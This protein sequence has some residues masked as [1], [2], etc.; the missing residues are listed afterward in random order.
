MQLTNTVEMLID[1]EDAAALERSYAVT[2]KNATYAK[3]GD[4]YVHRIV[5]KAKDGEIVDHINFNT[6]DNRKENLRIVSAKQS[7]TYRR[8]YDKGTRV[9]Q[10]KGVKPNTGGFWM[11]RATNDGKETF[12]G[13]Y[14][15]ESEAARAYD[16]FAVAHHGDHA[17]LN[18]PDF[19]YTDYVPKRRKDEKFSVKQLDSEQNEIATYKSLFAASKA[20]GVPHAVIAKVC[21]G[22]KPEAKG[23]RFLFAA[24]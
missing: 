11:A 22:I 4:E 17:R 14:D 23:F 3:C 5:M 10:Y 2:M 1:D 6:L 19:D 18:F 16:V 8:K 15:T 21:R 9:S 7:V 13:N 24:A 12:L 20:T